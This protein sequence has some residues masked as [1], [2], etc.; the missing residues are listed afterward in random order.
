MARTRLYPPSVDPGFPELPHIPEGWIHTTFGG[1]LE[2]V[3]R[4]LKLSPDGRY[5]LVTAKRNR[6]GIALRGEAVGREILTK[7]QFEAR[8]ND[9][10]I[11]RRQIIHGACG[12]VPSSLDGAV[13]SNEYSILRTRPP[14]L[15]EYLRQYSHSPYFQ[16]TC[17]HSS[18]GVDV[19]KMIFKI[20]EW[21]EREVAI[22]P[23]NEQ[24]KIAAILS[25]VDD[26][27]EATQAVIDQLQV[28]K[29]AMM[30]ELLARG[31]PGRH[32]RFKHTEIGEVPE[33][34]TVCRVEDVGAVDA[35]KARDPGASGTLRPYLRVANVFDGRIATTD[36][37]EMPFTDREFDRFA[38][39]A[40]DVLLNEGQSLDLV[41]R[42]SI[43]RGEL[44]RPAAFQN[45]LLRFRTTGR[46]LA[47]FAE[48]Y[49]RWCQ[50]SGRFAAI[51][52][53]TT[54]IAH[55]GLRRFAEMRM[56]VPPVQE[57]RAIADALSAF[58][59]RSSAEQSVA[60]QLVRTK[61]ALMSVLLTG[62]VRVTPDEAAA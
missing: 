11:S 40:G 58:D 36:V 21:L 3:E 15:M 23:L 44:G 1:V 57:Q 22:P 24:R 10:L 45:A 55:L 61:S 16:R 56:H 33:E 20:D 18:H 8:A 12:V 31:L 62:E 28:V 38:L 7:T 9:F 27:I 34:W 42:C 59:A 47:E 53:Q 41:G 4:P 48:Q 37:N 25:S 5:R 54:S 19:E 32:T 50:K 26:A 60:D 14:L 52:T 17:F 6:G 30:A 35:G 49:F 2:V 46:V 43:Y 39:S 51:A 29:K 13:V